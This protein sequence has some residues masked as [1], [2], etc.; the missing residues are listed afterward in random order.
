M[1]VMALDVGTKR[2]G[3]ALSDPLKNEERVCLKILPALC[4]LKFS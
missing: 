2:I 1:R 3:V 4:T